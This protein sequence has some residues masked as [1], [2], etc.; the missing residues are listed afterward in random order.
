MNNFD[1][2]LRGIMSNKK[3]FFQP[4]CY[5]KGPFSG[6]FN[7][8][9]QDYFQSRK[10]ILTY[11]VLDV[12]IQMLTKLPTPGTNIMLYLSL[13]AD[14]IPLFNCATTSKYIREIF[15]LR[16]STCQ[17]IVL[18]KTYAIFTYVCMLLIYWQQIKWSKIIKLY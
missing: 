6:K 1:Q 18:N 3:T 14:N 5:S 4:L 17:M 10:M 9:A 15:V 8:S 2:L 12:T 16:Y 7:Y 11:L 13:R